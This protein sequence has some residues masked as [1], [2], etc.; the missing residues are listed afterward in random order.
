MHS[1]HYPS[2]TIHHHGDYSGEY[3]IV[4]I[5]RDKEGKSIIP[6]SQT[7]SDYNPPEIEI[8][9]KK[10]DS[11]CKKM[12]LKKSFNNGKK[13][14]YTFKAKGI[15]ITVNSG[16]M[17]DFYLEKLRTNEISKLEDMSFR[18]LIKRY[19]K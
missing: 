4:E 5:R 16:E 9:S 15:K 7:L 12:I 1:S 11:I 14:D 6:E 18:Q 17:V 10:F 19:S 3:N 2:F 13:L 8:E